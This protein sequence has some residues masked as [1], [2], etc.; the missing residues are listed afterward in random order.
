MS[1]FCA[2]H[3]EFGEER[4]SLC[5]ITPT[6]TEG[7][8]Q[9]ITGNM[10]RKSIQF[11]TVDIKDQLHAGKLDNALAATANAVAALGAEIALCDQVC[12]ELESR[13]LR[14]CPGA[15]LR[16][17]FVVAGH[18]AESRRVRIDSNACVSMP[19]H[20]KGEKVRV[21]PHWIERAT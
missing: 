1:D 10:L 2:A 11:A 13:L 3:Q 12:L 15:K 14:P 18:I 21:A 16:T 20:A 4:P 19:W 17:S 7:I 5:R 8:T 6:P 9:R